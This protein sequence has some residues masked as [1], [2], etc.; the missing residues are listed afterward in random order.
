LLYFLARARPPALCIFLRAS[1][2]SLVI[3]MAR[4]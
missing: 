2:I 3:F 4:E 1:R